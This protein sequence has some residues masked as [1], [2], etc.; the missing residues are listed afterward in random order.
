[1]SDVWVEAGQTGR[2]AGND[3]GPDADMVLI[4]HHGQTADAMPLCLR[5]AGGRLDDEPIV[6]TS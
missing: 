3:H 5:V 1:M 2:E 4:D 6:H